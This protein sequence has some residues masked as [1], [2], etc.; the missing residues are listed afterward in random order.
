MWVSVEQW[1]RTAVGAD[2]V[3]AVVPSNLQNLVK[4]RVLYHLYFYA[5]TNPR[6]SLREK[7]GVYETYCNTVCC[8][9]VYIE[10]DWEKSEL[11][12]AKEEK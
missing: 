1:E 12:S 8:R 7:G 10:R 2:V 3:T 9:I 11:L 6:I 5:W 4:L